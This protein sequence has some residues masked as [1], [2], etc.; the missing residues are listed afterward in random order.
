[1]T[2][3][4]NQVDQDL[5]ETRAKLAAEEKN[6]KSEMAALKLRYESRVNLISEELQ[7]SQSQISRFKRERDTFRHML[8]EAQSQMAELKS[9]ARNR[10]SR[11]STSGD[12]VINP[13]LIKPRF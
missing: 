1:M 11:T 6:H 13:I 8:E 4:S 5:R 10:D 12:E 2:A 9:G 3:D 7:A